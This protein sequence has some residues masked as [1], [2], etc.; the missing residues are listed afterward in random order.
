MRGVCTVCNNG[1]CIFAAC[2][3]RRD[4]DQSPS[5]HFKYHKICGSLSLHLHYAFNINAADAAAA[6]TTIQL[7]N[8][9]R[10]RMSDWLVF[11]RLVSGVV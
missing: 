11:V 8:L 9:F 2:N 5:K 1:F 7:T 3:V 6:T 10:S 4:F